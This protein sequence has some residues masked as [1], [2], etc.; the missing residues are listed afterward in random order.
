MR[1]FNPYLHT[2]V[3][4]ILTFNANAQ[5]LPGSA[6]YVDTTEYKIAGKTDSIFIFNSNNP[7]KYIEAR[8]PNG[9]SVVFTWDFYNPYLSLLS[10]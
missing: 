9:D 8:S 1:I 5:L 10:G 6:N 4:L 2:T 7:D 3:F